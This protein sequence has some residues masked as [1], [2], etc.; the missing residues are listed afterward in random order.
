MKKICLILCSVI[1]SNCFGQAVKPN[2]YLAAADKYF[3]SGDYYSAAQYYEMFLSGK[4]PNKSSGGFNPYSPTAASSKKLVINSN[5]REKVVYNLAESYR[6]LH[7]HDKAAPHYQQA[8]NFDKS[9]FPLARF[10]Y[11]STLRAMGKFDEAAAEFAAFKDS[12]TEKDTYS[13]TADREIANL[14]FIRQQMNRK[15][16]GAYKIE[17]NASL[18]SEGGSYAPVWVGDKSIWF[19]STRPQGDDKSKN[20]NNRVY[21]ADM[22]NGTASNISV[23]TI[24]Q[25]KDMQQ[26]VVAMT[27]DGNTIFLTRWN[28]AASK[29]NAGI[30]KSSK[31][32][33][34]WT[35][36]VLVTELDAPGSNTQQPFVT[37]DGKY[38]VFSSDRSGG[39][40]GYDLWMSTL[41]DK[42]NVGAPLNMGEK[43]NTAFDEQAPSYHSPS[44]T[45]VFSS[46]GRVGMGGFDFYYAKG[47]ILSLSEP[48]NFGYP[49]N[50]MKDDLYFSSKGP[51]RNILEDV[52]ISSDRDAACCL[53]LFSLSKPK[54]VKQIS[55]QVLA[56]HNSQPLANVKVLVLDTINNKIVTELT[57]D[58]SGRYSFTMEEYQP[59]KASA[60]D[61]GYFKNSVTFTGPEDEEEEKFN[62]PDL[63][64]TLIPATPE[65]T[66]T[67]DNVYYDFNSAKLQK[68]SFASLDK[69]VILLKDNPDLKIE[70]NAHTDSKGEEEYNQR[71]SDARAQSVVNYLISKGI[72]RDRLTAKGFGES[73]PVADNENP[74]GTDNPEGRQ[75]NRR[76]EFKVL[77]K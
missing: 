58:A 44:G 16:L 55:G 33:K 56:C 31:S 3:A 36:P 32:D 13:S 25:P 34:G 4:K 46:N 30:Y 59:L 10:H 18:N 68:T 1:V 42:G 26:G 45:F 37:S 19:T 65:E 41:D 35:D 76:T 72:S 52:I 43:I 60:S 57:T 28:I 40:G 14:Q 21:Q 39:Y 12:Y 53:E 62:S 71:L 23:V 70:L 69:L 8:A 51:A 22:N 49:V 50:S 7:Y 67:V 74:D 75:K 64:L 27:P 24:A 20:T 61:S 2:E 11:A 17:K 29:R 5:S 15:T 6:K 47:N 54:P 73:M 77:E 48:K 66:I 38:L 63:C 9:A